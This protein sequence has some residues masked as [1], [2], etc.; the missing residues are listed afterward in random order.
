MKS[1]SKLRALRYFS[2]LAFQLF[3]IFPLAAILDL[4]NNGMSDVWEEQY[5]NGELYPA[6]FL[7][8][9][10]PDEDGWNN[11]TEAVAGTD[12]FEANP[13]D[14]IVVTQL[15]PT[16]TQGGYTLTWPTIVGKR[17][18]LQAS[19]ELDAWFSVG[20]SIFATGSS[21]SIGINA[22]QP[23][24]TV[25]PK[26]FWR[27]IVGDVDNDTDG[28]TNAEEHQLGTNPQSA[29]SD[30]DTLNDLAEILAAT[31]PRDNDTDEDGIPD[32]LDTT[33]LVNNAIADPD[34]ANLPAA[35]NTYNFGKKLIA[36]YDFENTF[37]S[38]IVIDYGKHP[39]SMDL[40]GL[41]VPTSGSLN[42]IANNTSWDIIQNPAGLPS[43]TV[44]W[45]AVTSAPSSYTT[46][47]PNLQH[48]AIPR[49][50]F[51]GNSTFS[52][53]YWLKCPKDLLVGAKQYSLLGI[54]HDTIGSGGRP[55]LH[56]YIDTVDGT[57]KVETYRLNAQ[58]QQTIVNIA[59]A[60]EVLNDGNWHHICLSKS[61][62]TYN[63]YIDGVKATTTFSSQT[64]ITLNNLTSTAY[65]LIGRADLTTHSDE[66]DQRFPVGTHLDRL[67]IYSSS[68]NAT[69]ALALYNQDI[70]N[71]GL[72]DR[73]EARHRL[74]QD[75]NNNNTREANESFYICRPFHHDDI[76]TD[77]DNDGISSHD[78]QNIPDPS[79]G[80]HSDP[81]NFDTDN[82]LLPDGWEK[83]NGFSYATTDAITNKAQDPDGDGLTNY[84]EYLKGTQP[85]N[86]DTDGDGTNDGQDG[87]PKDPSDQGQAPDPA[88]T[89]SLKLGVGDESG[90]DSEHYEMVIYT[91]DW[92]TNSETE[93]TR[94]APDSY[95][96]YLEGN[97]AGFDPLQ[98]YTF[99]IRWK[100]TKLDTYNG[101][102]PDLDYTFKVEPV[103]SQDLVSVS[104]V[105]LP[106]SATFEVGS[107]LGQKQNVNDFAYSTE[108]KRV[109]AESL[110]TDLAVD[111]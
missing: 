90:S 33:P 36:R 74:W 32:N 98:T 12:P 88:L 108:P 39:S 26:I 99:Q 27:V 80:Y 83:A 69:D 46:P 34:G 50:V 93:Y 86:N 62:S 13:P 11:A 51:N 24:T 77:H 64:S 45:S 101:K 58:I 66:L 17:Y 76:G 71:D 107:I 61:G 95:G 16:Q 54:G 96:D 97:M 41:T 31:N 100:G 2:I 29:D 3:S 15:E 75:K 52:V 35:L 57:I 18:R 73:I 67:R 1:S 8:S 30:G 79:S 14:G 9:N 38:N 10:D 104:E 6:T 84:K 44:R 65:C 40:S 21:H 25:P 105:F 63:T 110:P 37:T 85:G 102:G 5:N 4:N 60:P 28:L 55:T 72:Y 68:L 94:F 49:G 106:E 81:A 91:Y 22:V 7:P 103:N 59:T 109:V 42:V 92:E 56:W 20:N 47:I 53:C 19:Y 43:R 78:E 48:L 70:D 23:D 82:D 111:T 89:Y 87:N